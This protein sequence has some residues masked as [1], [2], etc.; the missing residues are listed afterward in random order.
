MLGAD[1]S[2]L[3]RGLSNALKKT[4]ST[5]TSIS[6]TISNAFSRV[7]QAQPQGGGGASGRITLGA[8]MSK[9][10]QGVV[11]ALGIGT[12]F[13][14]VGEVITG[15]Q[16]VEKS[17]MGLATALGEVGKADKF[18]QVRKTV[19]TFGKHF[20]LQEGFEAMTTL[21]RGGAATDMPM[22]DMRAMVGLSEKANI[23]LREAADLIVET[24]KSGGAAASRHFPQIVSDP[25]FNQQAS[26]QLR[27]IA[28]EGFEQYKLRTDRLGFFG[29][30]VFHS[31]FWDN[32][33]YNTERNR[34]A[35]AN[36][37][38]GDDP[39]S[40]NDMAEAAGF[41]VQSRRL[42]EGSINIE[43]LRSQGQMRS[44]VNDFRLQEETND[45]LDQIS[46][47]IAAIRQ[48]SDRDNRM[49]GTGYERKDR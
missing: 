30:T 7:S 37:I 8:G 38:L 40:H 12:L 28:R 24:R 43:Q 46:R 44:G 17:L 32:L 35:V 36:S 45:K 9:I 16:R 25:K 6:T 19:D 27:E 42:R 26:E 10:G 33:G 34:Q 20:S 15:S 48:N 21:V 13:Q 5:A 49:R 41:S 22:A 47:D 31:Q 2:G 23:S 11:G 18:H 1:M 29:N 39:T 3:D 4:S 14:V